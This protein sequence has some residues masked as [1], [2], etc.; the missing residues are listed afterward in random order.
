MPLIRKDNVDNARK[1]NEW[2]R[3]ISISSHD[4]YEYISADF[5]SLYPTVMNVHAQTIGF[6]LVP[7]QPMEPPH[8]F[9]R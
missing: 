6:D 4:R 1:A 8:A 9:D 2:E 3:L 7:V 5:S